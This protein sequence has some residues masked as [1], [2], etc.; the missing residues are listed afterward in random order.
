M[1]RYEALKVEANLMCLRESSNVSILEPMHVLRECRDIAGL[2]QECMVCITLNIK[3]KKISRHLISLGMVDSAPCHPRELFRPA[4][5][6]GAV[7]IVIV[8]NHPS[9]DANPSAADLRMTKDLVE[10]GR[11]LGIRVM[12]HVIVGGCSDPSGNPGIYSMRENGTVNFT[13]EN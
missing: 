2:A 7:S 12:D 3:N 11:I 9:G 4:I 8:H 1:K 5:T 10:A 13:Q 6:D